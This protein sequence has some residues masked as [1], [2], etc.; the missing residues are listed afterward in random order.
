MDGAPKT[1]QEA[2]RYFSDPNKCRGYVAA[3]RWPDGIIECPTCGK[4]K[5]TFLP[6]QDKWQCR[7]HHAKRQFSVKVGTIFEDS[8]LGLDKWLVAI[9]LI[10]NCKNGISSCEIARA[11]GVTQKTAWFMDHRIRRSMQDEF[12]GDKLGG[13]GAVM[14]VDESFVGGKARNMHISERKRR[15]TGTGGK[16]K[17]AVMG[18][19]GRG[20][21]I[22]LKVVPNRRKKALQAEVTG[23]VATGSALY[24][25]ALKSY[26]GLE[27]E[28]G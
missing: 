16:G 14:E 8:G 4:D 9:W 1:L 17:T 27:Q 5:P 24:S 10:A 23:H 15:I 21:K 7:S 3:W 19:W 11:L 13:P 12:Y 18:I 22:R 28:Y 6:N 25:D 2:V 26:D 20:G